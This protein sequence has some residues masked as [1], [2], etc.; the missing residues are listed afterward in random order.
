MG[1]LPPGRN[2]PRREHEAR[3]AGR[4]GRGHAGVCRLRRTAAS[5]PGRR[6][7]SPPAARRPP[8]ASLGSRPPWPDRLPRL[9]R[10]EPP[11]RQPLRH[12]RDRLAPTR[13]TPG[14]TPARQPGP[15]TSRDPP[16]E[17][18]HAGSGFESSSSRRGGPDGKRQTEHSDD[19]C[20]KAVH[21]E[22]TRQINRTSVPQGCPPRYFA[23]NSEFR[24]QG[25]PPAG[26]GRRHRD[27][28]RQAARRSLSGVIS[29]TTGSAVPVPPHA[30]RLRVRCSPVPPAE[31][32][33][34][35]ANSGKGT[36]LASPS[37]D[38]SFPG[39]SVRAKSSTPYRGCRPN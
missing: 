18:V 13:P 20:E 36:P 14:H 26:D 11:D 38:C 19:V 15:R 24:L 10:P 27:G 16:E 17:Q 37:E 9:L 25:R 23:Q 29:G 32:S 1:S 31:I 12:Q 6:R 4:P 7:S 34:N 35:L 28:V 8:S 22:N 33:A 5:R 2:L 21:T 30:D 39:P 3:P